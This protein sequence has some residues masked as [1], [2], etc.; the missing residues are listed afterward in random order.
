V[1]GLRVTLRLYV[2]G[3]ERAVEA[4]PDTA[5]LYVLRNDLGLKAAKFGCGLEQC[6]A[7]KV[8]VEGVAVT[9]CRLPIGELAGRAVT[10]LEGLGDE[11]S[12]HPLQRAFLA[13]NAGQCGYCLSGMLIS[14]KAL[15]DREPQPSRAQ[16][17]AALSGQL[18]RCGGHPRFVR[19]IERAAREESEPRP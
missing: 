9:S 4:E 11:A 17:V 8:L 16:I 19:A 6:G 12:P 1:A 14:A 3:I 5:L 18:C 10:T 15:L 7:C 2:N 13:E